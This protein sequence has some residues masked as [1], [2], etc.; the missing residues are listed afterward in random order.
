MH[1]GVVIMWKSVNLPAIKANIDLVAISSKDICRHTLACSTRIRGVASANFVATGFNP[2]E[3][4]K[5]MMESRRFDPYNSMR[6]HRLNGMKIPEFTPKHGP[7]LRHFAVF[8]PIIHGLKPVATI[9][10]G[11][12][13][14][15]KRYLE[16]N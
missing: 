1:P 12:M 11:P 13:A 9:C 5:K 6:I 8:W 14:L 7:C 2:W 15:R 16:A 10:F 4:V 3:K